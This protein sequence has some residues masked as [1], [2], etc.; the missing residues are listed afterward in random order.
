MV[1]MGRGCCGL[2]QMRAPSSK[3][4]ENRKISGTFDLGYGEVLLNCTAS[5]HQME[6]MHRGCCGLAKVTN[7]RAHIVPVGGRVLAG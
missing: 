3:G 1:P 7:G 2:E 4:C 6:P 5:Q